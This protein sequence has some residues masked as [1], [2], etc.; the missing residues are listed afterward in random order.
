MPNILIISEN[1][2]VAKSWLHNLAHKYSVEILSGMGQF[3][4][5]LPNSSLILLDADLIDDKQF[6]LEQLAG[7]SS[8]ILIMG[9]NWP[10]K[11]QVDALIS[12]SSGYC[13]KSVQTTLLFK[14]VECVLR[15]DIWIQRH[16]TPMVI[17]A[18]VKSKLNIDLP[19]SLESSANFKSLS[20]REL[21]VAKMIRVGESNKIIAKTLNISERTVKAHLTS[22]F[23]KINVPDRLHLALFLKEHG[24]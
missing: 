7:L 14:A 20:S 1:Q 17:G 21:D 3:V 10:E 2:S 19:T 9:N 5:P 23:K 15:G 11:K 18:L 13:A 16:L 6:S 8:K 24:Y 12:G 22:I 4:Q